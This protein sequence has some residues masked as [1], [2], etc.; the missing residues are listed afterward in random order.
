MPGGAA[1]KLLP[2]TNRSRAAGHAAGLKPA[3]A[4]WRMDLVREPA[5]VPLLIPIWDLMEA[6]VLVVVGNLPRL[7]HQRTLKVLPRAAGCVI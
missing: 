6:K 3:V 5:L 1:V 4:A 7:P 2:I